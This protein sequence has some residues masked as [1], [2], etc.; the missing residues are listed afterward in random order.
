MVTDVR[1]MT[2]RS[3]KRWLRQLQA[4]RMM[5]GRLRHGLQL[6]PLRQISMERLRCMCLGGYD[7]PS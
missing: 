7:A 2:C 6:A 1:V 4:E 5:R 3:S